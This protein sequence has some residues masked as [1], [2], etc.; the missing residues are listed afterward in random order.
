MAE[1]ELTI[2]LIGVFAIFALV[3]SSIGVYGVINYSTTC[4]VREMGIR[5]ALGASPRQVFV[6]ILRESFLLI[7][8]G[9][10]VGWLM[11]IGVGRILSHELPVRSCR[12]SHLHCMLFRHSPDRLARKLFASPSSGSNRAHDG[13]ASGLA[14]QTILSTS[15]FV[16]K[17][18]S[19]DVIAPTRTAGVLP[20]RKNL[21]S[22]SQ[23][24]G[25]PVN[26]VENAGFLSKARHS[27]NLLEI[28]KEMIDKAYL[29]HYI[30][31]YEVL[32]DG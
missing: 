25:Q 7:G 9:T 18:G 5:L 22:C 10:C 16:G 14:E 2:R 17:T 27:H 26:S 23:A 11:G 3:L 32:C 6:L 28:F 29:W 8:V 31:L 4:R 13:S 30:L 21:S 15:W 24:S 12:S 20:S 1:P 19:C